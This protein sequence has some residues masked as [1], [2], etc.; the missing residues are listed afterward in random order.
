LTT[1]RRGMLGATYGS[2]GGGIGAAI[3]GGAGAAIGG[4]GGASFAHAASNTTMEATNNGRANLT[5]F[6]SWAERHHT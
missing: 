4:G 5:T 6:L 3:G 1:C 2:S